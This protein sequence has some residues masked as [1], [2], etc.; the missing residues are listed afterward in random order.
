MLL[1]AGI[2][3]AVTFCLMAMDKRR[4]RSGRWRVRVRTLWTCALL[5]GAAGACLGMWIF[6]HKTRQKSFAIGLPL[7]AALQVFGLIMIYFSFGGI[8]YG[9]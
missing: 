4:A 1:A 5:M 7:L 6:R 2:W 8:I 9:R 3:N